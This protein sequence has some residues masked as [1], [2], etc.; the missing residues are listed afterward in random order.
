MVRAAPISVR[1]HGQGHSDAVHTLA[2]ARR[3]LPRSLH[4]RKTAIARRR[5]VPNTGRRLEL[6]IPQR[7][8]MKTISRRV[9]LALLPLLLSF[10]VLDGRADDKQDAVAMVKKAADFQ[11]KN[12][13]D[14]L[15]AELNQGAN[16]FRK[17]DIYVFAYGLDGTVLAHPA[18]PKL[19][20]K[21]LISVPDT[22]GKMFR[23][24]IIDTVSAKGSGWVDYK[25]TNPE[26]KKVEDKTTYVEK[27]GEIVLAC[28]VYK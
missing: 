25:Y 10:H 8:L 15:L 9:A 12:G 20:G 21:N 2:P 19:V 1:R 17:G 24:E 23:K 28:G 14:K 27:A 16:A 3:A 26:T 22:H 18:N 5:S 11:K 4:S 6:S 7:S 13:K